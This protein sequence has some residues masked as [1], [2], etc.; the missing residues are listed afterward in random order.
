MARRI[1][2]VTRRDIVDAI[3]AEGINWSGRLEEPEFLSRLFDLSS[4]PSED[5]RF[6][7]AAGDIWQHR[8][9][10]LD[11][12]SD[13]VF[14]DR[15]FN[16][17]NADDDVFLGFLCEGLHPVAVFSPCGPLNRRLSALA[18]GSGEKCGLAHIGRSDVSTANPRIA[19]IPTCFGA[20]KHP[21]MES[22]G[23]K[24][25]WI[26]ATTARRSRP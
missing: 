8:V 3:V 1:S 2:Q 7:D 25:I 4:L 14:Y 24:W 6:K 21:L 17:L 19:D 12:D 13:W 10:N 23:K 5:S 22:R 11:W 20:P 15:R 16:L 18:T 26:F 9:N